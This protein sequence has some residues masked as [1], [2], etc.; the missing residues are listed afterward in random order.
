MS[1]PPRHTLYFFPFRLP[2]DVDLLYRGDTV[3]PLEPQAVRVL[4]YLVGHHDRVIPKDELLEHVWPDAFTTDDVLKRAVSQVRRALG[5]DADDAR[6]IKTYHARGYRFVAPV[7]SS[8]S[9]ETGAP[10]VAP[11]IIG[12]GAGRRTSV[13]NASPTLTD[14]RN[15][16]R[17]A[18][19][20]DPDYDQ[21]V[22][23]EAE[24]ASLTAEYRSSLQGAGRP[25][26]ISGEPGIGKTQLARYFGEWV[27]E[28]GALCLYARF[29]DYG[30]SRLAPYELFL[31]FLRTALRL[32]ATGRRK[33]NELRDLRTIARERCGVTL[34]AELFAGSGERTG[35]L[36]ARGGTSPGDYFR[37]VVPV[38]QCFV[39]L[40]RERPLVMVLD[41]LQWADE[42][43]REVIGYLMRTAQGE[44]LMLLALAR[45]EETTDPAHP[46]AE[47]LKRQANYRSYT[48]LTLKPLDEGA[49]RLAIEAVFGESSDRLN[50][51][52]HDLR[53]LS[54]ATGGNPYFL[55]EMLRLLVAEGAIS[56]HGEPDDAHWQW[57][58]VKD[59]HLPDTIV[60]AA[61]A[62]LDRLSV[63]VR[64]IAE[65]AA[66]IGDEFRGETLSLM[67]DRGEEE[68]ERLLGEGVRR[69]VLSERGLSTGEDCRFYHTTL[70]RV[71]YDELPP[72]RRKRLHG[73]AARALEVVYAREVDRIA[74]ALSTHWEAAGHWRQTFEWSM[75][76]WRAAS[77][78]WHWDEAVVSI[79]RA[80]RAAH[81]SDRLGE[82]ALSQTDRLQLALA[83]GEG[84]YSVGRLK[85]S[86]AVLVEAITFA[87]V[88]NN[89]ADV[90][91]ALLQQGRTQISL[92]KYREAQASTEQ[93]LGIYR[94]IEDQ[95]G[96]ALALVQLGGVQ[97]GMGNYE[98]AAQLIEQALEGINTEGHTAAI[99]L[100]IL[101]W[102]RALQ[103][104]YAEGV[105]LLERALDYHTRTGD[106]RQRALLLRRLHWADLSRGQYETAIDLA[107]RARDD[108]RTAGD[109]SGEA[110]A[111]MGIGQARI[112]Q[113][114]CEE[115]SAFLNRTLKSLKVIGDAHCE[116]ET[117]WLLGRAHCEAGRGGQASALLERSLEMVRAIGDRDD[118][119]RVLIDVARLRI[120]DGDDE[121]G[122]GAADQA[123][124]IA[125]ELHNRD[126]LGAALVERARACLKLNQ[127]R[128]ALEAAERAVEL[129]DET[130]SGERWRGYWTLALCLDALSG[131]KR[132]PHKERALAAMR[133]SVELLAEIRE[134][135]DA[136]DA[137]RRTSV[138]HARSAP[139]RDLYAMLLQSGNTSEAKIISRKWLLDDAGSGQLRLMKSRRP[140]RP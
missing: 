21:L 86:E 67:A 46:L 108:F 45:T 80:R 98:A 14:R 119:F 74:E 127:S 114:L 117:L 30:G 31:D 63:E 61:H 51:P 20:S 82:N 49:C 56:Y 120:G 138:T 77:G 24:L 6:F 7:T 136:S 11:G 76:A 27:H 71:V 131:S 129:L 28:Q 102:A 66:V 34:P 124:A 69:G 37:A 47:W 50:L 134:Q 19:A 40:S 97:A 70:R 96:I 125:E 60:L 123:V 135:L 13:P 36:P 112:A 33:D 15:S 83:M 68:I 23:R 79:E 111:N 87:R 35:S 18:A 58:G 32:N 26:L 118:E 53:T 72:R 73:Q 17:T 59:L 92:S 133:R 91:A 90:S 85:D 16:V 8:S 5:D 128:K 103:G 105:P 2:S 12:G 1:Q 39:S 93:A 139:A 81:E 116:A 3:I 130:K 100:G 99:A 110:K 115:G 42:A 52:L 41:D 122:L 75:R 101:G 107:A 94:Q 126:V 64:E 38:S 62:K 44:P 55:T 106:V 57:R 25:V 113:G 132:S 121:G 84:F 4:R 54:R 10:D 137:A 43:S 109:I 140:H 29:F 48:S 22:G 9:G 88:L 95:K 104:R 89:Q 65:Q 78:R